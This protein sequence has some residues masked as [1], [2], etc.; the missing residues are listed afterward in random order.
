MYF[1]TN[2]ADYLA[3]HHLTTLERLAAAG[4][5]EREYYND[6]G[7]ELL[8]ALGLR[9]EQAYLSEL[10][11]QGQSVVS[12]RTE[13]FSWTDAANVTREAMREG[14]DAVYQPTFVHGEWGG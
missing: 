10:E 8:R 4:E 7:L 14:V 11:S 9:H 3:C 12:I 2:I 13:D 6:A 1:A 5:I